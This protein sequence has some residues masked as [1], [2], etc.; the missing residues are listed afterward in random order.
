MAPTTIAESTLNAEVTSV[1][2]T[3]VTK[4]AHGYLDTSNEVV[5]DYATSK[6]KGGTNILS[7]QASREVPFGD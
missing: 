6:I 3:R 4:E 1:S 2:G 5:A 7:S